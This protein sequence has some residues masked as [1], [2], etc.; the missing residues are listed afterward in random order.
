MPAALQSMVR[1][2]RRVVGATGWRRAS[3]RELLR[4]F[5]GG[6]EAAFAALVQRHGPLVMGICRRVLGHQQ[7][8]EDAFQ[9]TFLV[10][11]RKAGCLA[12]RESIS[13][14]L[15]G[16]ALRVAR[17]SR[18]SAARRRIKEKI[19]GEQNLHENLHENIPDP[20]WSELRP[21]LD[22]ELARLP[23]RYRAPLILCYLEGKT[24]D[25]AAE[26]LRWTPGSVKGRLERGRELLRQRVG[27]RGLELGAVLCASFLAAT[28]AS[29]AVPPA[30]ADLTVQAGMQ[31]AAG[32]TVPTLTA[33][34]VVH[35]AQGVLNAM[36]WMK[37]KMS[38]G[39]VM[40]GLVAF[41]AYVTHRSPVGATEP[42]RADFSAD[43]VA[44]WPVAYVDPGEQETPVRG[45][46]QEKP[47][48]QERGKERDQ[49]RGAPDREAPQ[50]RGLFHSADLERRTL[51]LMLIGDGPR[52]ATHSYNLAAKDVAVSTMR[53]T[54]VKLADLSKG[55]RVSLKLSK[56]DDVIAIMVEEPKMAIAI[57]SVDAAK[58]T[59]TLRSGE[60]AGD[61]D[62]SV[63]V[64]Q[65]AA[66]TLNG[67]P[68][69][70]AELPA[71]QRAMATFSLDRSTI[72]ALQAGEV[73][74]DEI[75]RDGERPADPQ[76]RDGVRPPD[77]QRR[78]GER[79]RHQVVGVLI[80]KDTAKNSIEVL[81]GGDDPQIHVFTLVKDCPIT[82]DA[83]Q[84]DGRQADDR[85][86]PATINLADLPK[87]T[88]V[89]LRLGDERK[90]VTSIEV[91]HPVV[92]GAVRDVDAAKG[93]I[94]LG[95]DEAGNLAKT[96]TL[97]KEARIFLG[98]QPA[99]LGDLKGA[100]VALTLS[101]DRSQVIAVQAFRGEGEQ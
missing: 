84:A 54:K 52:G 58:R 16:V 21:V 31:F 42:S 17:K 76:R 41:G 18:T 85:R 32:S 9:A 98:R 72:V 91:F 4:R 87:A 36:M 78:D 75:R 79:G 23:A 11:A 95:G 43:H 56:Q 90:T 73:R 86:Q 30:I 29:A 10:L 97:A 27:R 47:G 100:R 89:G 94:T 26:I 60:R 68:I 6:D 80:A 1:R 39:I 15:H 25:E 92:R 77:P 96:Y 7:D 83:R 20:S 40:L 53:G 22:E 71:Q 69:T 19:A 44:A 70:L 99:Q 35:L 59:V 55:L 82:S 37:I 8:A 65:D 51:T 88:R 46:A 64:A 2:L 57:V 61:Q 67:K 74:R 14:W 81:S 3:D 12:W 5:A 48:A 38:A 62:K 66:I 93:T 63:A 49:E 28:P 24:R 101:L 33:A 34:H 13:N 50:V 45:Q